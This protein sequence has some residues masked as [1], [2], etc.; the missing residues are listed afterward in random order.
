MALADIL[1]DIERDADEEIARIRSDAE[2]QAEALVAAA[3]SAADRASGE[4][5]DAQRAGSDEA[6]RG[7][8]ARAESDA[9][10]ALRAAREEAFGRVLTRVRERLGV[11]RSEPAYPAVLRAL[12]LEA[13]GALPDAR[14]VAVDPRDAE[15]AARIVADLDRRGRAELRVEPVLETWGGIEVRAADA[16]L[17]RNTLEERLERALPRARTLVARVVPDL[18]PVGEAGRC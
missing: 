4:V 10:A 12:L 7:L 13:L 16:R 3:R 5:S 11:L 15:A 17:V 8:I 9:V 14:V 6:R 2:R 1:A 18:A